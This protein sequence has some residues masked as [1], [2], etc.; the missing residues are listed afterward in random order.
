MENNEDNVKVV[1]TK[2]SIPTWR[3]FVRVLHRVGMTSY[4]ALQNF[5]DVFIRFGDDRRNLRPESELLMSAFE[6]QEKWGEQFNLAD[7][8]TEPEISEATYY[9]RDKEKK[10][11]RVMH[12]ERPFFGH[13]TETF[14]VKQIL[15]KFLCMTFPHLYKRL[16]F[17]AVCRECGSILELLYN[18]VGEMEAEENKREFTQA[19]EDAQRSEW[20]R[21]PGEEQYKIHHRRTPDGEAMRDERQQMLNFDDYGE[22]EE[23]DTQADESDEE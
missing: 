11:V 23:Q 9:I 5:I 21:E 18:V 6:K 8:T 13:W 2:V 22:A 15:E 10:G 4:E 1:G 16:R 17:I 12:V 14:N 7:P 20:G 19:F 3:L